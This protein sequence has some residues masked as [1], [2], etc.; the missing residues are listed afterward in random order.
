MIIK[1]NELTELLT[2]AYESGCQN[3]KI[4]DADTVVSEIVHDFVNDDDKFYFTQQ[5]HPHVTINKNGDIFSRENIVQMPNGD[6]MCTHDVAPAVIVV[7][8]ANV[9]LESGG[10]ITCSDV[11][12]S[13]AKLINPEYDSLV[14]SLISSCEIHDYNYDKSWGE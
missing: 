8:G 6:L 11:I 14:Q 3:G 1:T 7:G 13:N 5:T 2:L 4:E 10:I 9:S 12:D